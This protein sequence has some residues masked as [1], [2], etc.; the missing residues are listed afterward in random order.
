LPRLII[1]GLTPLLSSTSFTST[2]SS[3]PKLPKNVLLTFNIT[4]RVD[5]DVFKTF[6]DAFLAF[7]V[8][9]VALRALVAVTVLR[10]HVQR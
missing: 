3:I 1:I 6:L 4:I 9:V 7:L 2:L 10:W 5:L 8:A